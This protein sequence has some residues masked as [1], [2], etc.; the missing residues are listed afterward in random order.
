MYITENIRLMNENLA[1]QV[2][3]NYQT[4][5]FEDIIHPKPIDTRTGAEIAADVIERAGLKL[6]TSH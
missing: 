6:V 5:K 1:K 3:G 4:A 2:G